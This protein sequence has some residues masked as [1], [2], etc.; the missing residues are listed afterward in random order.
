M[1]EVNSWVLVQVVNIII[2]QIYMQTILDNYI[3]ANLTKLAFSY[4]NKEVSHLPLYMHEETLSRPLTCPSVM[5]WLACCFCNPPTTRK[6]PE[7]L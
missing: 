2:N 1:L 5:G 7:K 3:T 6:E 4:L